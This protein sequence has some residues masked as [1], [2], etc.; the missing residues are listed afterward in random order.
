MVYLYYISRLRYTI[1]VGNPRDNILV[2]RNVHPT[3]GSAQTTLRAAS[4][5]QTLADPAGSLL[6]W[7]PKQLVGSMLGLLSCL[8]QR[9]GFDPPED[10]FPVEGI[11]PLEL[12]WVLTSFTQN[13]FD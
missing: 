10:F 12:I 13:S 4:V 9:R 5:R 6:Q 11:F 1:L 2:T 8:M 7:G 3:G